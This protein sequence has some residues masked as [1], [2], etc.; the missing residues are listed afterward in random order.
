MSSTISNYYNLSNLWKS[1]TYEEWVD[2][3]IIDIMIYTH[4]PEYYKV[5]YTDA[6]NINKM[7]C[8]AY[9]TY[10]MYYSYLRFHNYKVMLYVFLLAI[11][12]FASGMCL[13]KFSKIMFFTMIVFGY[14]CINL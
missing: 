1:K 2:E 3:F 5:K 14:Y 4:E 10:S 13:Y 11:F 12:L 6:C 8:P 9:N 7:I